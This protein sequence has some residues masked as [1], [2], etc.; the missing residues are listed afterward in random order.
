MG[1]EKFPI[2]NA[3]KVIDVYWKICYYGNR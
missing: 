2:Y 1:W 3:T